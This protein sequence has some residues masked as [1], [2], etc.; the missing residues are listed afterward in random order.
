MKK[1]SLVAAA[2]VATVLWGGTAQAIVVK[3]FRQIAASFYSA[4]GV[5]MNDPDVAAFVKKTE[6]RLPQVGEIEEI[7]SP[8]ILAITQL[9]GIFCEKMI[10]TDAAIPLGGRRHTHSQVDFERPARLFTRE[11]KES[12]VREYA[13][14]FWN[15][16]VTEEEQ[17]SLLSTFDTV[18]PGADT[19]RTL[20]ILCTTM[21]SSVDTYVSE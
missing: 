7:S 4:T 11:V 19:L 14:L 2:A 3:N 12:V 15:R 16:E 10:A 5:S 9:A 20:K 21:A 18:A 17:A 1:V 6:T 13:D 8:A